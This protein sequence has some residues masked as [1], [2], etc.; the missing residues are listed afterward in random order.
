MIFLVS[1]VLL[2]SLKRCLLKK[3]FHQLP[4]TNNIE[5]SRYVT[6]AMVAKIFGWQ[7]TKNIT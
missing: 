3:M 2:L 4:P 6:F 7:Q 5:R 1:F